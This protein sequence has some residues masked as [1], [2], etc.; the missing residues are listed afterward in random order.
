MNGEEHQVNEHDYALLRA[1][2]DR[3]ASS[4]LTDCSAGLNELLYQWYLDGY[5]SLVRTSGTD[6]ERR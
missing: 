4:A 5:I 1:L 2:A 3:R 6:H